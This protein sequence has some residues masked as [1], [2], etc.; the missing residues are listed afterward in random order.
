MI[1]LNYLDSVRKASSAPIAWIGVVKCQDGWKINQ[2]IL[3]VTTANT[4]VLYVRNDDLK[5]LERNRCVF[6]IGGETAER[7]A[8][9]NVKKVAA[10]LGF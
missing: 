7:W 2:R 9:N 4:N 10:V 1:S 3:N 6:H 8:R 5:Y